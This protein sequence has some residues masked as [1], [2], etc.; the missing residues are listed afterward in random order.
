MGRESE[1][2]F[3]Q[4]RH[5]DGQQ[6]HE[7]M[8]NVTNY[9]GNANQN[10]NE[11]MTSHLLEWLLPKRQELTSVARDMENRNPWALLVGI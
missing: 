10:Y 2:T 11:I 3:F 4:K 9:Q 6:V 7:K 5:V 8:L 1:E